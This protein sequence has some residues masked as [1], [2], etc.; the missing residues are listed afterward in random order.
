MSFE[1]QWFAQEFASGSKEN[2]LQDRRK[3]AQ[4]YHE[5]KKC[6][7]IV[8]KTLYDPAGTISKVNPKSLLF[9]CG[10]DF[11]TAV[12]EGVAVSGHGSLESCRVKRMHTLG[13]EAISSISISRK[14]KDLALDSALQGLKTNDLSTP[15]ILFTIV[16]Q[17]LKTAR[18]S[19]KKR[20]ATRRPLTSLDCF[21]EDTDVYET[22][23]TSKSD[24]ELTETESPHR[25]DITLGDFIPSSASES[26]AFEILPRRVERIPA[27]DKEKYIKKKTFPKLV[28]ISADVRAKCIF[29]IVDVID[30]VPTLPHDTCGP[31]SI[32]WFSPWRVCISNQP[33]SQNLFAIFFELRNNSQTLRVRVNTNTR[34]PPYAGRNALIQMIKR[35]RD[36]DTLFTS[37]MD[38]IWKTWKWKTNGGSSRIIKKFDNFLPVVNSSLIAVAAQR[39][40]V[41][42]QLEFIN[43]RCHFQAFEDEPGMEYIREPCTSCQ[44]TQKDDLFPNKL[45]PICR[46]CL[47]SR[48][49]HQLRLKQF[50]I[51]IPVV[52]VEDRSPL[53]LLYAVLPARVMSTFL[54]ARALN[55][56]HI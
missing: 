28:D 3:A 39:C 31:C 29:E 27:S 40:E 46:D 52:T 55:F 35:M 45:G 38:F 4:R 47:V 24:T 18:H 51:Q 42:D 56:L 11:E 44:S 7:A 50:P 16:R 34:Y 21:N 41:Y 22:C 54:E 14:T 12:I 19:S 2:L 9:D 8:Y 17:N 49:L 33:I 13:N 32:K 23:W 26:S 10:N 30:L 6:T 48:M 25:S 5:L 1:I 15:R 36:F 20:K 37:L 43:E 53:E